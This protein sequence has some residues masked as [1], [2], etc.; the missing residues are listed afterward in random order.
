[1]F[2]SVSGKFILGKY[3]NQGAVYHVKVDRFTF[4]TTTG[5]EI[6]RL[7]LQQCEGT[8]YDSKNQIGTDLIPGNN[9]YAVIRYERPRCEYI[10]VQFEEVKTDFVPI[11]AIA[12]I[13][14]LKDDFK[15]L[16][17]YEEKICGPFTL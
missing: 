5:E 4:L 3:M 17:T 14:I 9:Y 8:T 7:V 11:N 10:E 12:L 16:K 13:K 15:I 1:M 6:E 2:A